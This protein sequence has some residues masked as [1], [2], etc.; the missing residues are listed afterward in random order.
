M[1]VTYRSWASLHSFSGS[2]RLQ[3]LTPRKLLQCLILLLRIS[4]AVLASRV[5]REASL[6]LPSKRRHSQGM[7]LW[8]Q[9]DRDPSKDTSS[10]CYPPPPTGRLPVLHDPDSP[11]QVTR[12][13]ENPQ[14]LPEDGPPCSGFSSHSRSSGGQSTG[15]EAPALG[16]RV[17]GHL[18]H[19]CAG[20]P[21]KSSL[22]FTEV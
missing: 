15:S 18:N 22:T 11:A 10:R 5:T 19:V 1:G 17:L 6:P 14:D 9:L 12:W 8:N 4:C 7:T 21:S 13:W 2:C 20:S 3:R 16:R